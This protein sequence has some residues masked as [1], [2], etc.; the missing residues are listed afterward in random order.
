MTKRDHLKQ[1]VE[2][3]PIVK[4]LRGYLHIIDF[5]LVQENLEILF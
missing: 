1:E 5:M 4:I 2:S 3:F